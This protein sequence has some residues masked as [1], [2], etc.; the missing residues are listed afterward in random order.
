MAQCESH[1][2]FLATCNACVHGRLDGETFGLAVAE[3]SLAGLPVMTYAI[4]GEGQ[5]FHLRVL[6]AHAMRYSSAAELE[7]L[8]SGFDVQRAAERRS[9]YAGLYAAFS[10]RAVMLQFL[11]AFDILEAA[12]RGCG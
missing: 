11:T 1:I 7:T 9:V 12:Q 6:G 2:A 10:A 4:A 8:M 3:C 5:D